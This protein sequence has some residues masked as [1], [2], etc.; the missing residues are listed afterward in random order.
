M[1]TSAWE[2]QRAL[3][4]YRSRAEAQAADVPDYVQIISVLHGG[5][6]LHYERTG[7]ALTTNGGARPWGPARGLQA[8]IEHWG[9]TVSARR[10]DSVDCTEAVIRAQEFQGSIDFTGFVEIRRY[11]RPNLRCHMFCSG[12]QD[13][14]GFYVRWYVP[15]ADRFND[16]GFNGVILSPYGSFWQFGPIAIVA[17]QRGITS[18]GDLREYPWALNCNETTPRPTLKVRME[19]FK[20]GIIADGVSRTQVGMPTQYA[21]IGGGEVELEDGTFTEGIRI[22]NSKD[23][24]RFYARCWPSFGDLPQVQ[25]DFWEDGSKIGLNLLGSDGFSAHISSFQ[26]RNI[27]NDRHYAAPGQAGSFIPHDIFFDTDGFNGSIELQSGYGNIRANC[28]DQ[29]KITGG[30]W[31]IYGSKLFLQRSDVPI[32][33]VS[34]TA[35]VHVSGGSFLLRS[36]IPEGSPAVI[37]CRNIVATVEGGAYLQMSG[38]RIR[39]PGADTALAHNLIQQIGPNAILKVDGLK[40]DQLQDTP[41]KY[42]INVETDLNPQDIECPKGQKMLPPAGNTL[43]RYIQQSRTV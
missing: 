24:I 16:G 30:D 10:E 12:G 5:K 18:R 3:A 2:H 26:C 22:G 19:G 34:G 25:R 20:D 1:T 43:G 42:L 17:D 27:I 41:G 37:T 36:R 21:N 7:N 23:F 4:G 29:I 32:L 39:G 8:Y 33:K 15:V 28:Q 35:R 9:A 40:V 11:I 38:C 13:R 14:G 6:W 31:D